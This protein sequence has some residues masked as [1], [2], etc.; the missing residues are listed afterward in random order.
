MD[1]G[2]KNIEEKG[3]NAVNRFSSSYNIF[4]PKKKN[5]TIWLI[6]NL[7]LAD[8]VKIGPV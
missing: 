8:S 1:S 3:E 4:Y 6:L 2:L 5:L 7:L